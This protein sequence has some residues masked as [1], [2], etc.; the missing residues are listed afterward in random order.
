MKKIA[1]IILIVFSM[2]ASAQKR[3]EAFSD[4][5]SFTSLDGKA[6]FSA[7]TLDKGG[8]LWIL[9]EATQ[10]I[11][12]LKDIVPGIGNSNPASL[13]E[14]NGYV[15]FSADDRVHGAELWRTD[16]TEANTQLFKDLNPGYR[17]NS[18]PRSFLKYDNKMYF[19]AS[20]ETFLSWRDLWVTDGTASG[21]TK[22]F[23]TQESHSTLVQAGEFIYS[24]VGSQLLKYSTVTNSGTLLNLGNSFSFSNMLSYNDELYLIGDSGN[25]SLLKLRSDNSLEVIQEFP[26][27]ASGNIEIDNVMVALNHI[28][29]TIREDFDT[30]QDQQAIWKSDGT[31]NGT[32]SVRQFTWDRFLF[33]SQINTFYEFNGKLYFKAPFHLNEYVWETNGETSGTQ[34]AYA[35]FLDNDTGLIG[36]G[37]T[38]YFGGGSSSLWSVNVNDW[39]SPKRFVNHNLTAANFFMGKSEDYVYFELRNNGNLGNYPYY[40]YNSELRPS[41]S[42]EVDNLGLQANDRIR[43]ETEVGKIGKANISVENIGN[44]DLVFSSI[45][46]TGKDLYLINSGPGNFSTENPAGIFPRVIPPGEEYS[47]GVFFYP[48]SDEFGNGKITIYSNAGEGLKIEFLVEG[49]I[50]DGE[51][52][53]LPDNPALDKEIRFF[54]TN[55][56][57]LRLSEASILENQPSNSLVGDFSIE[58]SNDTFTYSLVG[59]DNNNTSFSIVNNQLFSAETFN[60][61]SQNTYTVRVKAINGSEEYET[62]FIIGIG[63]QY[64]EID[65]G[66]CLDDVV[67]Q[68]LGLFDVKFL[69]DTKVIAIGQKGKIIKSLD[70]GAT[71]ENVSTTTNYDLTKLSF[72]TNDIGYAIGRGTLLKT[73]DGGDNWFE[74]SIPESFFDYP[75]NVFFVDANNGFAFGPS[76][77]D[78]FKTTNGGL[79]WTKYAVAFSNDIQEGYFLNDQRGFVTADDRLLETLDGGATWQEVNLD[80]GALGID[81]FTNFVGLKFVDDNL[82]FLLGDEGQ[83]IR[84]QDSGATWELISDLIIGGMEQIYFLDSMNG[85]ILTS[86]T[87]YYKTEDGGVTWVEG[88]LDG[89]FGDL[90]AM[91]FNPSTN[92]P[93]IVG[94]GSTCCNAAEGKGNIIIREDP[95]TNDWEFISYIQGGS[96]DYFAGHADGNKQIVFNQFNGFLTQDNGVTWIEVPEP[97]TDVSSDQVVSVYL[98]PNSILAGNSSG[99]YR[100]S[101]NGQNWTQL[102][103]E[104]RGEFQVVDD[105]IFGRAGN[106]MIAVSNDGGSTWNNVSQFPAA[107]FSFHFINA[108]I[109]FA[110]GTMEVYKTVDG[111]STWNLVHVADSDNFIRDIDFLG[112]IAIAATNTGVIYKTT[113]QG[114]N[115]SRVNTT[116]ATTYNITAVDVNTWFSLETNTNVLYVSRDQ[117]ETWINEFQMSRDINLVIK[118]E[119]RIFMAGDAST[120][121]EIKMKEVPSQPSPING[122]LIAYLGREE[123]YGLVNPSSNLNY[124]WTVTGGNTITFSGSEANVIWDE[125]GT[126]TLTITPSDACAQGTPRVVTVEVIPPPPSTIQ[127]ENVVGNFSTQNYAV[128]FASDV[129]YEWFVTGA[130]SFTPNQNNLTVNWDA[131]VWGQITLVITDNA[132]GLRT[133]TSL[134]VAVGNA[135]GVDSETLDN[136]SIYPNPTSEYV[137]FKPSNYTEIDFKLFDVTGKELNAEVS[138]S[139]DHFLINLGKFK[140]GLYFLRLEI[141]GKTT[142]RKIIKE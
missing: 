50:K 51:G 63:D 100:T 11:T 121:I 35:T 47:F 41:M 74:L 58:G 81:A 12:L 142:I 17:T 75:T 89:L 5:T 105:V 140:A 30:A 108:N 22:L 82:G 77:G 28:F 123:S 94:E 138:K 19:L 135:L 1:A 68:N 2:F 87:N 76:T 104:V 80:S 24:R 79:N 59:S 26:E 14:F 141:D 49:I 114:D 37:E 39:S 136:L 90:S 137:I 113:D 27:P 78:I 109:G 125:L 117:G 118:D 16:G 4:I 101:D 18:N 46:I 21:T 126:F 106:G 102:T 122:N 129:T 83:V 112:S 42:F 31:T 131:D 92:K 134:R 20:D 52:E 86:Y 64:E 48:S 95:N 70:G 6:Y 85:Y 110:Y 130:T 25:L 120:F 9:D 116:L 62:D 33:N 115:W 132:T 67:Y 38:L 73:E 54:N 32:V 66:A 93:L 10:E 97:P 119:D 7:I 127:G 69:S 40:L 55:D 13:V 15:Y 65:L 72:P 139:N 99:I 111:G 98:E 88:D 84:T 56:T 103:N 3:I 124:S 36:L 34:L 61:E 43:L 8:E 91:D 23:D 71:W 96:S 107:A 44:V 45:E 133:V 128:D 60:F 53:D 57:A 29:F